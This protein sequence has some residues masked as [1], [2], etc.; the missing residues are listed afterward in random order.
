MEVH[1]QQY[2]GGCPLNYACLHVMPSHEQ[3]DKMKGRGNFSIAEYPLQ[4]HPV[5][6]STD[7]TIR[8]FFQKL[9]KLLQSI[10]IN[11]PKLIG[12][13]CS[14]LILKPLSSVLHYTVREPNQRILL[15]AA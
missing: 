6:T 12:T 4:H 1:K 8:G 2:T 5:S 7:L 10:P 13:S 11:T 14:G 15:P 9:W 3:E